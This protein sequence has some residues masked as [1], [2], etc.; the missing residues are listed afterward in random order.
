MTEWKFDIGWELAQVYLLDIDASKAKFVLEEGKVGKVKWL[1]YKEFE[2]L[3]YSDE[4][5]PHQKEFKDWSCKM[6]KKELAK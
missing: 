4:F 5:C 6:M 2:K 1:S 3:I